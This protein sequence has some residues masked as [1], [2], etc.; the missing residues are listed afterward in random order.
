MLRISKLTDYGIVLLA[1]FAGEA[2]G[3]THNAREMA[4][5]TALPLPVV[6]K[7]LKT[8]AGAELLESLRGS[9]GGYRLAREPGDVTVAE[10][11]QALEGPIALMEC[12]VGPGHC[13]QEPSCPV[14]EPWQRINRAVQ[15]ALERVTLAELARTR[16]PARPPRRPDTRV[17]A[18]PQ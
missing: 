9:K 16:P 5:E 17:V 14:S 13:D 18:A 4:E 2:P 1:H 7:M 15:S 3:A 8:L 12:A 10:I 11:I 6:S